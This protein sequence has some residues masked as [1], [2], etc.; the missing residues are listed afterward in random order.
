[1]VLKWFCCSKK[2]PPE[3]MFFLH[4]YH[5]SLLHRRNYV[6]LYGLQK[7]KTPCHMPCSSLCSVVQSSGSYVTTVW[8]RGAEILHFQNCWILNRFFRQQNL[9]TV[10]N[11]DA[12]D[13]ASVKFFTAGGTFFCNFYSNNNVDL[14]CPYGQN[15]K[16]LYS[17]LLCFSIISS[18]FLLL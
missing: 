16:S 7:P 10:A 3:R 13:E 4:M 9:I 8:C 6:V 14:K 18:L 5:W 12:A 17:F 1:M 11:I 2:V 15:V